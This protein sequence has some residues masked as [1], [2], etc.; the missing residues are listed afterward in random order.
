MMREVQILLVSIACVILSACLEEAMEAAFDLAP[1]EIVSWEAVSEEE[2][3][4]SFTEEVNASPDDFFLPEGKVLSS[5]TVGGVD[6]RLTISPPSSPGE[7]LPLE[8]RVRDRA[9][10]S[11]TFFL[12]VYGYNERLPEVLIN[13]FTTQGSSS[14]PD[15]VEL[16]LLTE[17]NIGGLVFYE[18]TDTDWD[19]MFIFPPLEL[20]EGS[21]VILHTKPDGIPEERNETTDPAASGGKDSHPSAWDF[22]LPEGKGLSG[23]NGVLT[24]YSRPG[25]RL[26]DA[27]VYSTG[28]SEKYEGFAQ[29]K[30]LD[31][32]REV[33]ELGGWKGTSSPLTPGDCIDPDPSTATRSICRSSAPRDTDTKDDWHIVPTGGASFGGPNSDEVYTP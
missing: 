29:K 19:Q 24:L 12:V 33:E 26:L 9:G 27:V 16:Y 2:I 14:H 13:E 3:L 8:G 21:F 30:V 22:W 11:L 20:P 18:G 7:P 17:G 28:T 15:C 10:N 32:V 6:L 4:I 31:R 5:L 25:G 23:N 1:P